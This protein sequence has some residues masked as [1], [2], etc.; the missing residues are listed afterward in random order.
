MSLIRKQK[1]LNKRHTRKFSS[2][3]FKVFTKF[4]KCD[5]IAKVKKQNQRKSK[6]NIL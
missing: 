6:V 4:K 2:M 5:K 1:I 3:S